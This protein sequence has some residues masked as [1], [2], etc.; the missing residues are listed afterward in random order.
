M[1]EARPRTWGPS[2]LTLECLI[3]AIV[4]ILVRVCQQTLFPVRLLDFTICGAFLNRENLVE[5]GSRTFSDPDDGRLLLGC[6]FAVLVAL[7]MFARSRAFAFGVG[8]RSRSR[9]HGDRGS[10]EA[11]RRVLQAVQRDRGR[12]S[13]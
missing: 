6:V 8:A 13:R 7:V 10:D 11:Y 2:P 3:R 9:W 5:R 4:P 1:L 12:R